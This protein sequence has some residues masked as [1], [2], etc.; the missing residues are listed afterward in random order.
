MAAISGR[1]AP[2][3]VEYTNSK[4]ERVAKQFDNAYKARRFYCLQDKLGKNPKVLRFTA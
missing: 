1:T 3:K 4:G 2:C